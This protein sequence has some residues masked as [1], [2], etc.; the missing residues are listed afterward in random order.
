MK[1]N[2]FPGRIEQS[3]DRTAMAC[4]PTIHGCNHCKGE[5]RE[6][7]ITKSV[8]QQQNYN[9]KITLDKVLEYCWRSNKR[10]KG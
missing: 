6:E 5:E 1:L 2:Q 10:P 7:K 4:D 8:L 9:N 3:W